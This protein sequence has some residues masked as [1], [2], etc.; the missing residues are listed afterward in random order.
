MT[1]ADKTVIAD[2]VLTPGWMSSFGYAASFSYLTAVR[3][4]ISILYRCLG[5]G[6]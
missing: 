3:V 4:A 6:E 1:A 5:A 2:G